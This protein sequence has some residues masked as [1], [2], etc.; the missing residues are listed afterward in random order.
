M[1]SSKNVFNNLTKKAL[2][3]SK[4]LL[5]FSK[6][7]LFKEEDKYYITMF[8]FAYTPGDIVKAKVERPSVWVLG[9]LKTGDMV[10]KFNCRE[11]R[12]FSDAKYENKCSLMPGKVI[13]SSKAFENKTFEMF[14]EIRKNLLETNELDERLYQEYFK[15]IVGNISVDLERFFYDL[16]NIL[17]IR[18]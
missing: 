2:K 7:F 14:D 1:E 6:P 12:E 17:N 15:R 10:K 4:K 16:D 3:G 18:K 5:S 13:D 8:A 11:E 9:D